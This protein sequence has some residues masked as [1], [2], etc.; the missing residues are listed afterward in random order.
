MKCRSCKKDLLP[1]NDWGDSQ[2]IPYYA[3]W[4][5]NCLSE[6]QS[7]AWEYMEE[8]GQINRMRSVSC[9]RSV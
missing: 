1:G 4:C 5:E 7:E 8:W 2:E 3:Q 9:G 6:E